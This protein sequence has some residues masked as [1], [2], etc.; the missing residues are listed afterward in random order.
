LWDFCKA[1]KLRCS[2]FDQPLPEN[3]MH[4][5]SRRRGKSRRTWR[6][7][8][9]RPGIL[10]KSTK[11]VDRNLTSP[12]FD[13]DQDI[14]RRAA[15]PL[16]LEQIRGNQRLV[17]NPI[18]AILATLLAVGLIYQSIRTRNVMVFGA[19]CGLLFC[20]LPLFQFHCLDCG[21]VGW[22]LR[23]G[24]HVCPSIARRCG[25][26]GQSRPGLGARTQFLLWIYALCIGLLGYAVFTVTRL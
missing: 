14:P 4:G 10:I 19:A 23:S 21:A 25:Q 24:R 6:A 22:Y 13:P 15:V 2:C 17:V 5:Y 9:T 18:L 7:G 12:V 3:P 1:V 8:S 20:A 11:G 26:G 16:T